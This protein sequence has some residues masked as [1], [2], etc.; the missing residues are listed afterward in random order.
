M[1]GMCQVLPI[2]DFNII[3][4]AT[5]RIGTHYPNMDVISGRLAIKIHQPVPS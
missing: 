4:T 3:L 5:L 2:Y 1:P